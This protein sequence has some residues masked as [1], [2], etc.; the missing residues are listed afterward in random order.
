MRVTPFALLLLAGSAH[1]APLASTEA[2]LGE[3]MV[4]VSV[5]ASGTLHVGT[6]TVSLGTPLVR[7]DI[8]AAVVRSTPTI[9]VDASTPTESVAIVLER[10]G[11]TWKERLRTPVGGVGLDADYGTSVTVTPFGVMRYQTRP[12]YRRCDGKPALLFAEGLDGGR[13]RRLSR[14]PTEVSP[15]AAV[16]S[17]HADQAPAT[18]P[19]IYQARVASVQPGATSAGALG[20]PS[21]LDDGKPATAWR[22]ELASDGEGQFFT[23]EPRSPTMRAAQ[24]RVVPGNA[25]SANRVKRL[26]IVSGSGAWHIDVPD[27]ASDPAGTAY[28]AELPAPVAGCVTAV[29]EATYGPGNG[30]TSIAELEVFAEGERAGGGEAALAKIVASG[31][32]G[33]RAA[34]QQLARS[35]AAGVA[36][37]DAELA[38]TTDASARGRL[39]H[40]LIPNRDASAGPLLARAAQQGWVAGDDLLAAIEA[41]AHLNQPQELEKIALHEG[42]SVEPRLAAIH[43]LANQPAPLVELA[44]QGPREVR[45]ATIVELTALPMATLVTAAQAASSDPAA[46]DLWRAVT[47]RAR[48]TPAERTTALAALTTALPAATDYERRYRIVDGLATLGDAAALR[49]IGELI[50]HLP[51]GP[52]HGAFGQVA[53]LAIAVNPRAE[54]LP[55]LSQ[56]ARDADPGVRLAALAAFA[57]ATG[58]PAGPWHAAGGADEI[59]RLV[60]TALASDFWPEVRRRAAQV[61][62]TRCTRPGPARSLADA[63]GRDHDLQVRSDA[64]AALVECHAPGIAELLARIWD[65]T[66]VAVELRQRAVDLAVTLGD[67]ALGE[68]L[69]A[70]LPAWRGAA[71]ESTD[72]LALA[73][74][75]AYAL[76][77]LAPPGAA[78]AL[79]DALDDAAYPEIVAAAATGLGLM[80]AACP[81]TAIPKLRQ[82]AHTDERQI[83]AAAARAAAVC[84]H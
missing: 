42:L 8:S 34:E 66:R 27:G 74:N 60:Q 81:R 83:S 26:A 56:L 36:A 25:R 52:D 4:K 35:G 37:I 53:A 67:R 32:D 79:L 11:A 64:L 15:D 57:T 62:G 76:G 7:A 33:L 31:A 47:R 78:D 2:N 44:G 46:G 20:I 61:L 50:A 54:A 16:I 70:K 1:A 23:F 68:R 43:A 49:S 45:H 77:K 5:D 40:A 12:G 58:G 22:E 30:A 19:V 73:Q 51:A 13:F 10:T 48:A 75:A 21:E 18:A 14:I 71:L 82:L 80:G 84:G 55:L 28:V 29:I 69:V 63:I 59:D 24:I 38:K 9:V 41:L 65:D 72:A 6:A 3:G 17:A 39:V